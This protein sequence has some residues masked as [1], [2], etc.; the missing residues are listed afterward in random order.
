VPDTALGC[1]ALSLA[2]IIEP[3]PETGRGAIGD[4]A[5]DAIGGIDVACPRPGGAGRYARHAWRACEES[6][7]DQQG[8]PTVCIQMMACDKVFHVL[9]PFCYLEMVCS[10]YDST[11]INGDVLTL[12]Q[13]R[14]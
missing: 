5:G 12:S 3:L 9:V 2:S 6:C 13:C 11:T 8:L 10:L 1:D 7:N 4:D 14:G